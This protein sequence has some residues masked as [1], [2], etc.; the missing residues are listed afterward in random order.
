MASAHKSMPIIPTNGRT[1]PA[2]NQG[3]RRTEN[4]VNQF[5]AATFFARPD[6]AYVVGGK[7]V[8]WM[9]KVAD[10]QYLK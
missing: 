4:A 8:D 5:K 9:E 3:S 7:T 10:E 2:L 6:G 1:A